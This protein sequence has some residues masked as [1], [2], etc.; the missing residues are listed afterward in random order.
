MADE[1][2]KL[3]D[4]Q[5]GVEAG[6]QARRET[7]DACARLKITP[8]YVLRKLKRLSK[9]KGEKVFHHQG[10]LTYSKPLDD[11][12]VQLGALK[13]LVTILDMRP[14]REGDEK[15]HV[16]RLAELAAVLLAGPAP[17]DSDNGEGGPDGG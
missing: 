17:V 15:P 6:S 1:L 9:Y 7:L 13:E 11:T 8:D 12:T 4:R 10:F 3:L 16:D 5:A 14:P 2:K